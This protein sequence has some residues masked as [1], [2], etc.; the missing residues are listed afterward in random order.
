M[1][2]A[3]KLYL[4]I[5]I[6]FTSIVLLI[7]QSIFQIN[8]VYENASFSAVNVV[9]S[10]DD[11]DSVIQT[12]YGMRLN[13]WKLFAENNKNNIP[14]FQ[15]DMVARREEI[16]KTLIGYE[17]SNVFNDTDKSMLLEDRRVIAEYFTL[18]EKI[19]TTFKESNA[20]E[21]TKLLIANQPTIN[22]AVDKIIKHREYN[23]MLGVNG[24]E[25]ALKT[26]KNA[27]WMSIA[28]GLFALVITSAIAL[29]LTRKI[30][31]SLDQAIGVAEK[32]ADGDL[33][34]QIH[35]S[36]NDEIAQLMTSLSVMSKNLENICTE[37]RHSTDAISTASTEIAS[38]NLD[39][40]SRTEQQA[41]ALEETASSMEEMTSTVKQNS[42]NANHASKLAHTASTVATE[43]G[44][45]VYEV[46]DTMGEI[47][48]SA[49][50]IVDIISVIDGIAFQT[51]ILALNAAVEAARAGE[52][53]RGFAVVA[54]EV[55]NLAHRSASAAKEIKTLIDTS[56]EK[57]DAGS[58]LVHQAGV[59]MS[60]IVSS[61]KKVNDVVNEISSA[62]H[63]QSEGI[64]QINQAVIQM[65][66]TTQQNA[67]LVEQAAAAASSLQDQAHKLKE[68]VSVFKL[69]DAGMSSAGVSRSHP[70]N[71]NKV[72]EL[73]RS[74]KSASHSTWDQPPMRPKI[75]AVSNGTYGRIETADWEEF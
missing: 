57:V 21:A 24:N 60:N 37:L 63:E 30:K 73:K 19:S 34:T 13:T 14:A 74:L 58:K 42:D 35:V 25:I 11:L 39:L 55:R 7:G 64:E 18:V 3:K 29:S 15:Q 4:L 67:A 5:G 28:L 56:V 33:T 26:Q 20:E 27:N 45:I 32:I 72:T 69:N 46:V 43:G 9:P 36:G 8:K 10:Y 31:T 44:K 12:L 53:G 75:S 65:D 54:T 47:N 51:N 49:K 2:I 50:K 23:R 16:E 70:V 66:E 48:D 22:A 1:T 40:S 6:I 17:K 68:V 38:G 61:I 62:N 59:A 52:Q 71:T 41:G